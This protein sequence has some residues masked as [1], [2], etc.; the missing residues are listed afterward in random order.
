M[1]RRDDE[2]VENQDKLLQS[3]E[4]SLQQD[5]VDVNT[6][7]KKGAKRKENDSDT[8]KLKKMKTTREDTD[9]LKK[10]ATDDLKKRAVAKTK[11]KTKDKNDKK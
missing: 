5:G 10:K 11:T 3:I 2:L 8:K 6:A 7:N 4:N 9:D 1:W